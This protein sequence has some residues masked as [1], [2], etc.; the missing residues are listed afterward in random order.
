MQNARF[1]RSLRLGMTLL[2]LQGVG[3]MAYSHGDFDTDRT[4]IVNHGTRATIIYPGQGAPAMPGMS[5]QRQWNPPGAGSQAGQQSGASNGPVAPGTPTAVPQPD[6]YGQRTAAGPPP[7]PVRAPAPPPD[8][9]AGMTFIGGARED[10]TTHTKIREQP[11]V[12]KYL[13]A[14]LAVAA[15]P[16]VLAKEALVGEPE[17][18]P[19]VPRPGQPQ[20]QSPPPSYSAPPVGGEYEAA[21]Q[22][23]L[24]RELAAQQAPTAR[25]AR[26]AAPGHS[27][28]APNPAVS[29]SGF[30][31][32]DELAALQRVPETPS[33]EP[34]PVRTTSSNPTGARATDTSD[35]SG[36]DT[37]AV[38]AHGIVDRNDDGR[39]DQWI[40]RDEGEITRQVFDE[41]YDGVPDRTV[42]FDLATHQVGRVEEDTRG[43]GIVDSWAEYREGEMIR[44]RADAS[45]DGRIDTWSFYR[46]GQIARNEQDTTQDGYRDSISFYENGRIVREERDGNGDGQSEVILN[47]DE[48][49]QMVRRDED[50][51]GDGEIDVRSHYA[52][53]KLVRREILQTPEVARGEAAGR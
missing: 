53:G 22:Q 49:E 34:A 10:I 20:I 18:G 30:S 17:P 42:Y 46:D 4:P 25:L 35:T 50:R 14:P 40:Y 33:R 48:R 13:A 31:I 36:A 23:Q 41:N 26:N 37:P 38:A 9:D 45:G 24:E 47:F 15:A 16:F 3:C 27:G 8:P 19:P 7:G 21:M 29:G 2:S 44:R 28:A 11:L 51:D 5:T 52:A 12:M 32:S 1:G 6:P 43:D 39:I